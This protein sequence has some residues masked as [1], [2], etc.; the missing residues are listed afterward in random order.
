MPLTQLT[1]TAAALLERLVALTDQPNAA[2]LERALAGL[3]AELAGAGPRD[4]ADPEL[5]LRALPALA[6]LPARFT[7]AELAEAAGLDGEDRS[8]RRRLGPALRALGYEKK[9]TSR[10]G[11][12]GV[13]WSVVVG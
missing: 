2:L 12:K 11:V 6:G 10:A 7:I 4:R 5:V 1:P 13:Y 9:A 3:L 8:L